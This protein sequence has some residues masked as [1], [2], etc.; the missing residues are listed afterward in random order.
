MSNAQEPNELS[1]QLLNRRVI[2]IAIKLSALALIIFW[3]FQIIKPFVLIVIW[4]GIMAVALFPLHVKLTNVLKGNKKLASIIIAL[5]GISLIALPSV[6]L[7][8]SSI[9]AAQSLYQSIEDGSLKVPEVN[10]SVKDWPLIG[11]QTYNLWQSASEDL[12]KVASQYSEQIKSFSTAILSMAAG[13]GGSILQFIVSLII[14]VVFMAKSTSCHRGIVL[15]MSRMM[16]EGGVRTID[17]TV[18]TIKSVAMGVLG[19]AV[20]QS[21]LS[22]VGL[23]IAGIPAAGLWAIA[24]LILAIAQLPPIIILGP[25]AAYYFSVA[26]T[27]PAVIFLIFSILVSMSDA[28]L[29]PLFLGR[30]MDIPMLVILLGAIGGMLLSGIIGLFVGAVVL[31]LGY[32]LMMDWLEHKS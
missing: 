10:E 29:K 13:I 26:D 16:N 28:F 18:A 17:T 23:L 8:T 3:C 15:L 22:G 31:A 2:D 6:N 9:D 11:Q 24:V 7:S 4:G 20:I 14:A 5:V 19:V 25:I 21:L 30:G 1:E 32:Q 27:T 12:Q